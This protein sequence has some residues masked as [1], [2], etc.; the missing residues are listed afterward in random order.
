MRFTRTD[1]REIELDL[2]NPFQVADVWRDMLILESAKN[3]LPINESLIAR[4]TVTLLD[5]LA[6]GSSFAT[7]TIKAFQYFVAHIHDGESYV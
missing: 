1:G 4:S 3:H 7:G 6:R 5:E 2:E